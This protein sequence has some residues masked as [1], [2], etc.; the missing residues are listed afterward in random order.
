M[1]IVTARPIPCAHLRHKG[2][3]VL[4]VPDEHETSYYDRY[5]ATAY[6]CTCTQK[7]Y[8]PDG[9]PAH[10]DACTSGRECCRT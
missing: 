8:G 9:K 6:W 7:P 4:S 2:M 5:D 1:S 3:Y 10:A